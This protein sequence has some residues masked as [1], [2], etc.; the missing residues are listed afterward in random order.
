MKK[1]YKIPVTWEV[2]G[3]M[4]IEASS[5]EEAIR[6]AE[7]DD[8]SLPTDSSYVEGSLEVNEDIIDLLNK[9]S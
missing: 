2:Y 1:T 7:E 8:A 5:L 4:E 6:K 9:M 3:V